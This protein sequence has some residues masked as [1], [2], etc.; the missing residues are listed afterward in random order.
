MNNVKVLALYRVIALGLCSQITVRW[1]NKEFQLW[2]IDTAIGKIVGPNEVDVRFSACNGSMCGR[3]V[4]SLNLHYEC[5]AIW[6]RILWKSP[7]H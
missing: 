7:G 4:W 3:G 2:M 5:T 6:G 1:S